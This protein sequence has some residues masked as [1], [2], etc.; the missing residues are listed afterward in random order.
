[1]SK[2]FP[3]LAGGHEY[4]GKNCHNVLVEDDELVRRFWSDYFKEKGWELSV[5]DSELEFRKRFRPSGLPVRFFF[6]QD[7]GLKRGIGCA[8]AKHVE[9]WSARHATYLITSYPAY[10]FEEE[11]RSGM[12]DGVY[13]KFPVEI[14]GPNYDSDC[15]RRVYDL[16]DKSR[17]RGGSGRCLQAK[18][19][20]AQ[21]LA[22]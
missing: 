3:K 12:I 9:N 18:T 21:K 8:L 4:T 20:S 17:G 2:R 11:V 5:F 6:D 1:M 10:F 7:F 13:P 16:T 19:I 22:L 15:W 14:F